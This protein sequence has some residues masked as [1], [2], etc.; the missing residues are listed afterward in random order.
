MKLCVEIKEK[1]KKNERKKKGMNNRS[2]VPQESITRKEIEKNLLRYCAL[3][4]KG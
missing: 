4:A 3:S 1:K 2:P